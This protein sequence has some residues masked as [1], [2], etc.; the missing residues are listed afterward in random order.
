MTDEATTW[1]VAYQQTIEYEVITT[2]AIFH[3]HNPAILSAGR[4]DGARRFVVVDSQ[5]ERLHAAAIQGYFAA[6]GVEARIVAFPGGEENKTVEKCLGLARELDAFP[7]HRRDEPIIAIGGGVLTD[8]VGF[9]AGSYRRGMP[10][11]K[12][13]TTLMGYV[14]ASIGIK[15]GVNFDS[16]KNRLG[17]FHPPLRV[18]LD[19]AF[20]TTLPRR[21]LLNGVCE[22]VKLAVIRDVDLFCRLETSGAQSIAARFQDPAGASILDRAVAGM[23]SELR[24]NL[25]E[26][27][28]ERRMDF[29]HTF[30]YGLETQHAGRLLHGEA[31]MLDILVCALIARA[32]SLLSDAETGRIFRLTDMLGISVDPSLLEPGRLWR[33]LAERTYHRNGL[34]RTPM[35][36]GIGD[37]VFLNDIRA[38]EIES[39]I[40]A[41]NQG[42]GTHANA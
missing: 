1:R 23:L 32:R 3:P 36:R 30:S 12:V 8:V 21:H 38:D 2:S 6:H 22:I 5:V 37:C 20:L 34:Q 28:L 41:L 35:P 18:L 4:I 19:R 24:P 25:F 42:G 16:N 40:H 17:A 33:S 29:G 15:T 13:P 10:Y 39:A 7:I 9:L 27:D 31:V 11:I 26:Q 14:D